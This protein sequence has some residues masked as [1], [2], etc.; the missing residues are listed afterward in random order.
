M[1]RH[2][3]GKRASASF[4]PCPLPHRPAD[5]GSPPGEIVIALRIDSRWGSG[6]W[7]EGGGLWSPD[8]R[9]ESSGSPRL[10]RDGVYAPPASDPAS[11]RVSAEVVWDAGASGATE[12][13]VAVRFTLTDAPPFALSAD[14]PAAM[15]LGG[16]TG[17]VL[18]SVT[19][20]TV[21]VSPGAGVVQVEATLTPDSPLERWSIQSPRLYGLAAELVSADQGEQ[22]ASRAP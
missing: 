18:G 3:P 11:V 8:I 16:A 19:T 14:V 6:H 5:Q 12:A 4:A 2:Q 22:P 10:V 1:Q 7:Y 21:R 17:K 20:H 9:L 15:H 13:Q